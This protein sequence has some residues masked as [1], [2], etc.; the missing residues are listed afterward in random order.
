MSAAKALAIPLTALGLTVSALT[1]PVHAADFSDPTWPCI[2]RKI[3]TLSPGLMWPFPLK[4]DTKVQNAQLAADSADLAARLAL[5]RIELADLDGAVQAFV[6]QHG[7]SP[8]T[9]G[10]VFEQAFDTLSTR[11]A[12][13]INGIGHFSMGQIS[14]AEQVGSLRIDLD[15]ALSA[16]DPDYDRIDTLEAQLD[17]DQVIFSDRQQSITYLCETPTLLERR[18]FGIAQML[19]QYVQDN[20]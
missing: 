9:L 7:A 2:Q 14:L 13:I 16:A 10:L 6:T 18:L 11:R 19:Q 15:V 17:W 8:E 20:G 5:R 1:L 12:R 4:E 3:E